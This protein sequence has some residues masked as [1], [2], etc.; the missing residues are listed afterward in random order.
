MGERLRAVVRDV[1]MEKAPQEL[2][3]LDSLES[4]ADERVTAV[5]AGR[6]ARED[7]LGF[8]LT[9]VAALITPV[10]W[11]VLDEFATKGAGAVADSLPARTRAGLRGVLRRPEAA[12]EHELPALTP[13]Q[14]RAVHGRVRERAMA[15]GLDGTAAEGLADAVVSRLA[16]EESAGPRG[17]DTGERPDPE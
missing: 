12:P 2:V 9:E 15:G 3:L 6:T 4:A 11:L 7:T 17:D 5:F 8:G 1:V 14:L 10:V 13:G 16:R